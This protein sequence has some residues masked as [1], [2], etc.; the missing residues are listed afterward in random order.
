[1]SIIH[2]NLSSLSVI[3]AACVKALDENDATDFRSVADPSSVM[4]I[5][6]MA[7]NAL[8]LNE[9]QAL[10]K[11]LD[12]LHSYVADHSAMYDDIRDEL[13]TRITSFRKCVGV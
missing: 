7:R 13:F 9:L 1:M 10:G 5:C 4:E 11:L 2:P 6:D 8:T 12:D 3:E